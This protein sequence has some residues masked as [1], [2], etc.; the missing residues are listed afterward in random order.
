M[1]KIKIFENNEEDAFTTVL[2][3]EENKICKKINKYKPSATNIR[4]KEN[5]VMFFPYSSDTSRRVPVHCI[6]ISNIILERIKGFVIHGE[7]IQT[8]EDGTKE[9]FHYRA[10]PDLWVNSKLSN[11]LHKRKTNSK[12]G[13]MDNLENDFQKMYPVSSLLN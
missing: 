12:Y 10:T 13:E 1:K 9:I 11:T 4:D 6:G 8:N 5:N 7:I 2:I 3:D